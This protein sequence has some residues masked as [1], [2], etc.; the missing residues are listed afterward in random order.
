M[1]LFG[2][3]PTPS[4]TETKHDTYSIIFRAVVTKEH[5]LLGHLP[6]VSSW[7][8][9]TYQRLHL[10]ACQLYLSEGRATSE[11]K[12]LL[13]SGFWSAKRNWLVMWQWEGPQESVSVVLALSH[14]SQSSLFRTYVCYFSSQYCHLYAVSLHRMFLEDWN[15]ILSSLCLLRSGALCFKNKQIIKYARCEYNTPTCIISGWSD[16]NLC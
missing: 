1:T 10:S 6:Q 8:D 4:L 16:N 2:K 13:W 14:K 5:Q 9:Q 7:Q 15:H 12:G 3:Y 11:Q